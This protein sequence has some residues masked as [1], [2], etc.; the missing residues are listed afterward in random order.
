[1]YKKVSWNY[2]FCLSG[3]RYELFHHFGLNGCPWTNP[4]KAEEKKTF[5]FLI[6]SYKEI[7]NIKN[8]I[9]ILK[10]TLKEELDKLHEARTEREVFINRNSSDLIISI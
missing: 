4:K 7:V 2:H 10:C 6:I 5:L 9:A 1:M 8:H 3:F